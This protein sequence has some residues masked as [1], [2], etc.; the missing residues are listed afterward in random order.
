MKDHVFVNQF[1]KELECT[2]DASPPTSSS[3]DNW[4]SLQDVIYN[5][6]A[7]TFGFSDK[8]IPD[9]FKAHT[10]M[11]FLALDQKE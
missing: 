8:K 10:D 3:S 5:K 9:C 11:T 1:E 2:L 4:N 7:Q 6:A